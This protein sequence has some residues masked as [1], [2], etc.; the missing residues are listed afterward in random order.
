MTD[1]ATSRAALT[2]SRRLNTGGNDLIC[3]VQVR[4][5]P[6]L[7]QTPDNITVLCSKGSR[8]PSK[9]GAK[10]VVHVDSA[11]PEA[12]GMVRHSVSSP[13]PASVR[14]VP[15]VHPEQ[16]RENPRMLVC[17]VSPHTPKMVCFAWWGGRC[18]A[19]PNSQGPGEKSDK[20]GQGTASSPETRD[21]AKPSLAAVLP[22]YSTSVSAHAAQ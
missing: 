9:H 2:H 17:C 6:V 19:W 13:H 7:I 20:I 16:H 8:T 11:L 18:R 22:A 4:Y 1:A 21:K 12:M 3:Q 10:L 14:G 15:W 5:A